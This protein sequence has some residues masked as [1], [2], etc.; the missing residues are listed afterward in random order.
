MPMT[1]ESLANIV[2]NLI[3]S[4]KKVNIQA[5]NQEEQTYLSGRVGGFKITLIISSPIRKSLRIFSLH[6]NRWEVSAQGCARVGL[7]KEQFQ[8]LDAKFIA[9]MAHLELNLL[10]TMRWFGSKAAK[11]ESLSRQ[12]YTNVLCERG[13]STS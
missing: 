4:K 11:Q 8:V 9:T 10:V 12:R 5:R 7:R 1:V 3:I 6:Y 2:N 13:Q